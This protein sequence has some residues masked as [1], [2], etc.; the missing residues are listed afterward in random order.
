MSTPIKQS[1]SRLKTAKT[2]SWLYWCNYHLKLPDKSN[3]GAFRGDIC[4]CIFECLG[5]KKRKPYFDKILFRQDVY[6]IPSIKRLILKKAK[7]YGIDDS[8][9]VISIGKMILAGLEY[10]FYGESLGIPTEA[11]SE[12]EFDLHIVREKDE[13]DYRIRGFIDKL[14]LYKKKKLA[15]IRDFKSSK[16]VFEGDEKEKN[17]QDLIYSLAVRELFPDYNKRECEFLFLKFDMSSGDD[18]EGILKMEKNSAKTLNA[19]EKKLTKSQKYLDTFS[20]RRAKTNY[21]ANQEI[22]PGFTGMIV[23]GFAKSPGELKKDG[24]PKWHCKFKFPYD[25]YALYDEEGKLIKTAFL[26]D[27]EELLKIK[28]ENQEV[29]KEHYEGCPRWN[30]TSY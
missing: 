14:F 13:V 18:S 21:S 22:K 15:L 9:N 19:F 2:C 3:E 23:C 30:R 27:Q 4:H 12:I 28:K 25:Y 5:A 24:K 11:H 26:E 1:A 6:C 7:K 10:D 8:E 17:L 20:Q 16:R 29:K